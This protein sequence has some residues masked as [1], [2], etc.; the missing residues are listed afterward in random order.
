V[1]YR[2]YNDA[3]HYPIVFSLYYSFVFSA[4]WLFAKVI[5]VMEK[6]FVNSPGSKGK[7]LGEPRES[8]LDGVAHEE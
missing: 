2:Y 4:L 8:L 3:V 6:R 5:I 1:I 7:L